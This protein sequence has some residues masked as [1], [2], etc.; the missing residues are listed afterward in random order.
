[1]DRHATALCLAA[2]LGLG[3]AGAQADAQTSGQTAAAQISDGVVKI[4]VLTDLSSLYSATTGPGSVYAAELAAQDFGGKVLGMPITVLSADHQNKTDVGA[5]I[6]RRWVDQEQVDVIA[7]VPTSSIALAVEEITK[8]KNRVFLISGGGSSELT[9][10]ACSPTAIQWTYDTYSLSKVTAKALVEQGKKSWFFLTADYTFGKTLQADA[11][12]EIKKD[13]GTVLGEVR[14][15]LAT[16][17]FS[18]FLL[19]AQASKAQVVGLANAGGDAANAIKQAG[20]F[21]ITAGGQTLAAMLIDVED[22][23]GIGLKTA[24][25]LYMASAW[26]WDQDEKSRAFAQRFKAKLGYMPGFIQAGVYS[27]VTDYLDAVKAAG[28]DEAKAVVARMKATPVN[29]MF[30]T[31]GH[32]RADGRMAHDMYL[33]Q[34][35]TPAESKN[36]WDILKVVATIP[37]DESVRPLSESKCPLVAK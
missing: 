23:H 2:A 20:E 16:P 29:D 37:G 5:S 3:L 19:Q 32:V 31:N 34:V 10:S 33:M 35:K 26:Y 27:A 12:A 7:D 4:G 6:A 30:A 1:M 11:A 9:G 36:E 14:H 17:D 18:S 22:L 24:Q 28:T 8:E 25:G 15:P 13:G 21:G